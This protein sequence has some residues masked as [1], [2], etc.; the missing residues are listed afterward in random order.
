MEGEIRESVDMDTE[1]DESEMEEGP[2]KKVRHGRSEPS[3]D[4]PEVEGS[5]VG[6]GSGGPSRARNTMGH[7]ERAASAR[8]T[9]GDHDGQAESGGFNAHGNLGKE[10]GKIKGEGKS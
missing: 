7:G 1:T 3:G 4:E 9:L 10:H 5:I 2:S 8:H 6:S